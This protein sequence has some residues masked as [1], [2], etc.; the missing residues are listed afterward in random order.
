MTRLNQM[1]IAV[2]LLTTFTLP[3]VGADY[4]DTNAVVT[5]YAGSGFSGL[6]NGTGV[7]T[8]FN[9]PQ[10]IVVDS[11]SNVIVWD[12]NNNRFRKID[13]N[14]VVTTFAGNGGGTPQ[15][16]TGEAAEF[17]TVS[18]LC[19][20]PSGDIAVAD[21]GRIR[22]MTSDAV[23]TTL[24]GAVAGFGQPLWISAD[25]QGN[26]F[27]ADKANRKV[28]KVDPNGV[29]SP[30][31]GSGNAGPLRDGSGL[32][33]SFSELRAIAVNVA[34]EIFVLDSG[35]PL[36]ES[37]GTWLRKITQL[38]EVT[39][40]FS[41]SA[42]SSPVEAK[43]AFLGNGDIAVLHPFGLFAYNFAGSEFRL[44][45]ALPE[46]SGFKNGPVAEARFQV[47]GG[48]AIGPNT[49]VTPTIFLADT[50]DHRIR[51]IALSPLSGPVPQELGVSLFAGVT[52]NGKAGT[53][54]SI[55]AT[56]TPGS[57]ESWAEVARIALPVD[58]YVWVDKSSPTIPKRFYRSR[59]VR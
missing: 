43:L 4:Y 25:S 10:S 8:M 1:R 44:S 20:L 41:V 9:H 6:V 18:D 59:L 11:Q 38:G 15:D 46:G 47:L 42:A 29:V 26:I 48:M 16:G 12:L 56:S 31:A 30:L 39:T 55:E 45:G 36:G 28:S 2:A 3:T 33:C 40:L 14:Q 23:V 50:D 13:P 24:V 37:S 21:S 17:G 19:L 53:T 35:Q 5:T 54:Y 57:G 22:V 51:K 58:D 49:N 27:V 52:I 32:F 34:D 7:Q